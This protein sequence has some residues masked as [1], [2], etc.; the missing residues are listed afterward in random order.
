MKR[1][2]SRQLPPVDMAKHAADGEFRGSMAQ[3]FV[4]R[5]QNDTG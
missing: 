5:F 2:Q 4:I 3:I 1:G